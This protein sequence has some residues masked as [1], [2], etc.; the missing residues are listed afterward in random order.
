MSRLTIEYPSEER[1]LS[2]DLASSAAVSPMQPPNPLPVAHERMIGT[3]VR[4]EDCRLHPCHAYSAFFLPLH[5]FV[6]L[7]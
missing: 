3:E 4:E 2:T 5:L 1:S 7:P 6:I